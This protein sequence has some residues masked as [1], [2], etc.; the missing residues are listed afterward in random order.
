MPGPK[1]AVQAPDGKVIQFPDQF[2]DQDVNRE[3]LKLYPSQ[4][5]QRSSGQAS[6]VNMPNQDTMSAWNPSTIE[7]ISRSIPLVD[8]IAEGISRLTTPKNNLAITRKPLP[9][10]SDTRAIAPEQMMSSTEQA[11]RPVLT[12]ASEFAGGM[13]TPENMLL[14]AGMMGALPS[15]ITRS[16]HALFSLSMMHAAAQEYQPMKDAIQRGKDTQ[17]WSEA[18]RLGTHIMLGA[19]FSALAGKR[20][21]TGDSM[22]PGWEQMTQ[23]G[24]AVSQLQAQYKSKAGIQ[25][26]G[27]G[28]YNSIADTLSNHTEGL[29]RDAIESMKPVIEADKSRGG[30]PINTAGVKAQIEAT[31][32][33]N[34]YHPTAPEQSLLDQIGGQQV[35]PA[36]DQTAKRY[37]TKPYNQ[38]DQSQKEALHR[39][40]PPDLVPSG[41]QSMTIDKLM[42]LRTDIGRSMVRNKDA[43]GVATMKSAYDAIGDQIKDATSQIYGNTKPFDRYNQQLRTKFDIEQRG[44][45]SDML[46]NKKTPFTVKADAGAVERLRKFADAKGDIEE[47]RQQML[48]TGN[49]RGA[50]QLTQHVKDSNSIVA[51]HD[52]V[53]GKYLKSLSRLFMQHP[54]QAWPGIATAL[55]LHGLLPFPASF[56]VPAVVAG[57]NMTVAARTKAG[58]LGLQLR[59]QLPPEY[60]QGRPSP[61][62]PEE[63]P[64]GPGP[65]NLTPPPTGGGPAPAPPAPTPGGTSGDRPL[66]PEEESGNRKFME[67]AQQRRE[68]G[69]E[70]GL[71]EMPANLEALWQEGAFGQAPT[72]DIGAKARAANQEKLAQLKKAKA[73]RGR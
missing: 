58:R 31:K 63:G 68:H 5:Q 43:T 23:D 11:Q 70:R 61:M 73:A 10:M 53:E 37:F 18:K 3:M 47:V 48:K 54:T 28:L 1:W 9:G 22:V 38:L 34:G 13:T 25:S 59:S 39:M 52:A 71:K 33:S 69:V 26:S 32:A 14:Q 66:S 44:I 21:I 2:T 65:Q 41:T 56:L 20:A 17:D 72:E 55:A 51:A 15:A 45:T 27:L 40:I 36:V 24:R 6:A 35:D 8:R 12:G 60:F 57:G 30:T 16:A 46:E 50:D 7:R 42:Q 19:G 62:G 67:W 29:T 4:Q 64:Q 49:R